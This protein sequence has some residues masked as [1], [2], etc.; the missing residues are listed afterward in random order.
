EDLL[1]GMAQSGNGN[2]YHVNSPTEIAASFAVELSGLSRTYGTAVSLGIEGL[3]GVEILR[4]YNVLERT[5][6]GRLKLADLVQG[7]PLEV[8]IELLV[9][10]LERSRDIC[11]FRLAWSDS[12]GKRHSV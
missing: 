3:A 6:K 7:S 8:V 11:Q 10:A 12:D 1:A 4:V 5:A 2:F 9:P